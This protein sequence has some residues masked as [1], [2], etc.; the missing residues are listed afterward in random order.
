[1]QPIPAVSLPTAPGKDADIILFDADIN[2][3]ATIV[4]GKVVRTNDGEAMRD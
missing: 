2:V 4:E 3:S 1:L